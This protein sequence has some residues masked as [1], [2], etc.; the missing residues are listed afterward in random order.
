MSTK[1]QRICP[2][3]GNEL[4]GAFEFCPVCMLRKGL[5]GTVASGE[6][7]ASEEG[8]KP[9]S[10]QPAQ[11]FEHYELV[12]GEDGKPVEL[13]R[14]AMGVTYKAF[15]VDLRCPVTLKIISEQ[16]LGE[17]S[18][19]LR[20]LREARAAA[21]VRHPNVASVLHLGRTRSS[22]FY[23]MEFV[24]GETLE[25]LIRGSGRVEVK[26]ALEIATQVAAGLTAVHEQNLVH[27]DIKPSNIMVRLKD[28]GSITAKIIDLGLAKAVDEQGSQTAISVPGNFAGTPEFASPEQFAGVGVDI[29]SDLY[30]LG[31]VLWD[32]LTGEAP[33]RG[34]PAEVMYQHQHASLPVEAIKDVPKPVIGLLKS[35]L[36]KNPLRRPQSPSDL[37][38]LLGEVSAVLD[39]SRSA[40][41]RRIRRASKHGRA[42]ALYHDRLRRSAATAQNLRAETHRGSAGSA[43]AP[44][45]FGP[46]LAAKLKNFT[47]RQWL[48]HEIDEW[49]A[50]GSEPALL[51]I[52]E[53][54]IGKS[55][56]VAALVHKNPGG[57]VLAHHCFRA[58]TPATLEPAGFVRGLVAMLSARLGDYA[59]MLNEP[60]V[61]SALR[62]V[63]TD[64]AG[65][66]EGAI[67][68]PLHKVRTPK[69]GRQYF[70]I[71]GFDEALT[72]VQRPT[73]VE[74]LSTRLSLLPSWV[75]IVGTTRSEPSVL[76][77]LG[78]LRAHLLN[79][80]DPRNQDDL[81]HFLHN[82][83]AE[84]SLRNKAEASG[85]ILPALEKDLMKSSAGNFL[86]VTTALDAVES[87]QLSFD[88]IEKMPLGL[89]SLYKV[90]FDRLFRHAG[91]DFGRSRRV[92]EVIGAAGEPLTREEIAAVTGF[93]TVEEL[94]H[95]LARLA[96][97]VSVCD[98]RYAF[99]H[100]SLF[101]WLTG[102]NIQLDQ[103]FA[104]PYHAN[105]E[106]GRTQLADWCWVVYE[107]GASK[108]PAYC[109]RHIASHLQQVG[110]TQDARTVLLNFEFL[111]A[112]LEATDANALIADYDY[113]PEEKDLQLVQS[114]IRLSAH[115]LA[116]DRRQLAGQLTGRLLGNRT[117]CVQALLEQIAKSSDFV[118][119][120]PLTPS[121]TQPGGPLIR[122]LKD[123]TGTVTT[124]AITSEGRRAIS[125]SHDQTLRVWDLE[126]GHRLLTLEGHTGWVH[127]VAV[128]P[129]G[130]HVISG[131]RDHMLRVWDLES[132]Q[133]V[134]TLEGHTDWVTSVAVTPDGL[135]AISGSGDHTLRM[136]DL[137]SG[138]TLRTLEGHADIVWAVTVTPDGCRAIS[139]SA[140]HTLRVW[141][142]ESGQSLRTLE[143]HTSRV[144]AVAVT[145]D[146]QRAVSASV[147]QMLRLWDLESGQTIRTLEGHTGWV[148]AVAVMPEGRRAVSASG[149]R[150]L[151]LWDLESGQTLRTLQGHTDWVTAV[152]V[153]PDGL[154]AISGSADHTLRVWDL[155]SDQ[156]LRTLQDHTEGV[157]AA[158][159]LPDRHRGLLASDYQTLRVWDLESDESLRM[160]QGHTDWVTAVAVT[161]DGRRA[162]SG[163]AD[164]TLHVW[165]LKTGQSIQLLQAH[166]DSI[167]AVALTPDGH[168]AVSGSADH[169]LRMWNLESGRSICTLEVDTDLISAVAL[170]P[171]GRRAVWASAAGALG[172]WDIEKGQTA[173]M[174]DGHM[175]WVNSLAI[176]PDGRRAASV[177]ADGTLRVWDL[178]NGRSIR[179]LDGHADR[180]SFVEV[181]R[182]GQRA[183][184]VSA[185]HTLQV[186]DLESGKY[187]AG[188]T[189]EG[190]IWRF[191]VALDG[192][193]ILATDKLG[194]GHFLRLDG[195]LD[196]V[197]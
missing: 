20:F 89:S 99:F 14:G 61:V 55:A 109:V 126:N 132:G 197:D 187:L 154:C 157:T 185:D 86:F 16:Y 159:L 131:S 162:I 1:P 190:P 59:A 8:A 114:A 71:D 103:L 35:L 22:Y 148:N 116:R 19:R 10:D 93:D 25:H 47:G 37:Q 7:S 88:Q 167:T 45:D 57:Q 29:R 41:F 11:R 96:S 36:A 192:E 115:V 51:I 120:R 186:W 60:S 95:I 143:G 140:D 178:N 70:L 53:P 180:L 184:S 108:M 40:D 64:P 49:R 82:R 90:F 194:Q 32:M 173:R 150:T 181:T 127:A 94:P 135:C 17:E 80:Q 164:R 50:V 188:F 30:S 177:S 62:S 146:G 137:R 196:G 125:A 165:N 195:G 102:W 123:H 158:V 141:D 171:D 97:F 79:A 54:G 100:R 110:R 56:L 44:W 104:G 161:P 46:F 24:E 163:S 67:V 128:T 155:E 142:L 111:R 133:S 106:K 98:G 73:V 117:P 39:K 48:F 65:A 170:T 119:L 12:T 193:T 27:R 52:G 75:R 118:W 42:E 21:S 18:A 147:D 28:D 124:V 92:L 149:D 189:A 105:L 5:A 175:S 4:S 160:L 15:D 134:K 23:T 101:D 85:K 68:S 78:G 144:N 34:S 176:T 58:D 182:D 152:T 81:R 76:S 69:G 151:R 66:F 172:I 9:T 43:S 113:L 91:V 129:D 153:A 38:T 136:W 183:I 130:Q 33:F 13:G 6:S 179:M 166:M 74:I 138:Q 121:L 31:V 191:A 2:S 77:Q 174:L 169:T 72:R 63:D 145:P 112:K 156:S 84:P 3:C 168:R 139:G 26:L 87:G 122:T 83:L 107:R